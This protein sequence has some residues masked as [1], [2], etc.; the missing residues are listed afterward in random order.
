M[1]CVATHR[2]TPDTGLN[3]G[4]ARD[5]TIAMETDMPKGQQKT[6]RETRKPKQAKKAPAAPASPFAKLPA[7]K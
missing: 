7:A 4:P 2:R 6:N 1:Q 3:S 5:A